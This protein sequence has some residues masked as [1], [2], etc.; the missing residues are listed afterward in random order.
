MSV[1]K[2]FTI[3]RSIHNVDLYAFAVDGNLIIV[4]YCY[5]AQGKQDC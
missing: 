4:H 1:I 3:L 5:S 2:I